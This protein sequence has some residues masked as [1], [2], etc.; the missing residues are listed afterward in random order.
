MKRRLNALEMEYRGNDQ[1][2]YR[3]E[4]ELEII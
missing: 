2:E 3:D 1:R 4:K